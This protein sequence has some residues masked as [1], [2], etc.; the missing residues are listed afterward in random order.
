MTVPLRVGG[1]ATLTDGVGISWSLAEGPRGRRWRESLDRGGELVRSLL[2]ETAPSGRPTRLELTTA[3]GLLTLH[4]AENELELHG[5]V[6]TPG[7]I[8]HLRFDWGSGHELLVPGSRACTSV[9]LGRLAHILGP[10]EARTVA[11]LRIDDD[12]EPRPVAQEVRRIG[13]TAWAVR[14]DD[15]EERSIIVGADGLVELQDAEQWPL[16]LG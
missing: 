10:G 2:L 12:L 4:P 3:S 5:N 15:D 8:R 14:A 7:G 11:M 1:R 9:T 16:E 13:P 6:V